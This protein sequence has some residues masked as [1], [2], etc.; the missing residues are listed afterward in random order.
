MDASID[1]PDDCLQ[2]EVANAAEVVMECQLAPF[3]IKYLD[4]PLSVRRLPG[5][6]F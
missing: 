2:E 3:P 6:A 5:E 4:I 1:L